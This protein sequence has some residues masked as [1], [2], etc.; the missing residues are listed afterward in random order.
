MPIDMNSTYTYQTLELLTLSVYPF[1]DTYRIPGLIDSTNEA[2]IIGALSQVEKYMEQKNLSTI[3]G[4]SRPAITIITNEMIEKG[5]IEQR[6]NPE[7]KRGY[8]LSLTELG[9][10]VANWMIYR[11]QAFNKIQL[12]GINE[13]E[14]KEFN[15]IATKM[16]QNVLDAS[17]RELNNLPKFEEY[18]Q[19][20]EVTPFLISETDR[21]LFVSLSNRVRSSINKKK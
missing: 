13:K 20:K 19:G 5:L 2:L 9:K 3:S 18:Q 1:H 8:L 16:A 17:D 11:K 10:K 15:S 4:L 14:I 12:K 7:D 6:E 21:K